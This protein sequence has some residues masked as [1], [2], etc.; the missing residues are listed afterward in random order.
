[1]TTLVLYYSVS[2]SR[3]TPASFVLTLVSLIM[4]P[5]LNRRFVPLAMLLVLLIAWAW[6][7]GKEGRKVGGLAGWLSRFELG[8]FLLG[9]AT[10]L[11][12]A[13][14]WWFSSQLTEVGEPDI[15]APVA[16]AVLWERVSR[17]IAGWL[18]DQ[19]RGLFIFAPI[20]IFALW[21]WPF[22]LSDSLR[23]RNRHWFV[24]LPFLLS[25]GV[26]TI[27]GGF[28][29]AWE[30]GPRFLVVALPALAPLLALA[31][32]NYGRQKVW[33]GLALLLFALSLSNTLV[34]L[35]HLELPYKSSLPLY[36]GEK[37]G[38]PLTEWLPDLAGYARIAPASS[39]DPAAAQAVTENGETV[40]LAEPGSPV[41]VVQPTPLAELP[42][43][44]YTL[45]WPLRV[46]A[47]LPPDTELLRLSLK[48]SGGG[49]VLNKTIT[50]ADLPA[51]GSYG[52]VQFAFRNPNVD[53]WRTP[54]V[55]NA[56]S[57]GQSRLWAGPVLF[58]P[59]PFYALMLPYLCLALLVAVAL[60]TWYRCRTFVSVVEIRHGKRFPWGAMSLL[61]EKYWGVAL[62]LPVA[63]FGYVTYQHQQNSRTYAGSELSHFV[64][65]SMTDP[66]AADGQAWLVDP[67]VDPPQKAVYGP[68]DIFDAGRY[69]VAF[70]LKLPEV[71]ETKQDLARLQ[72]A[73]TANFD[74]LITQPLRME[75]FAKPNLYHDFVLTV[76]NPRRQAL[77]FEIYYLG[78]APLLIDQVTITKISG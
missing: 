21:G 37:I 12:M 52:E 61:F 10:I 69:K 16:V 14:L 24:I 66:Q 64:G 6:R 47:G 50:A 56:T 67:Q 20:Y 34:I 23:R 51:D 25:L 5:W 19:Q 33:R 11:S 4:L 59:D 3:A 78:I 39:P 17:G 44:H 28:W 13:L 9:A 8:T 58:T 31:W 46:E 35:Y 41:T 27:A 65:R 76:T 54:P 29:T 57:S 15:T 22:L 43:G 73:A 71:V 70:R 45:K 36:Y 48:L 53:R 42:F 55:F 72:V 32:R 74:E 77:S 1:L 62:I 75:H 2:Q 38:L 63:A 68:F 7:K 26:T 30:L 40:W 49:Q 60:L 18:V